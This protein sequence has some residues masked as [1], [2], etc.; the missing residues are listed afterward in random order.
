MY[1]LCNEEYF[2]TTIREEVE[3]FWAVYYLWV[4]F[5]VQFFSIIGI[6]LPGS[7]SLAYAIREDWNSRMAVY[8]S[9]AV[10]QMAEYHLLGVVGG[11]WWICDRIMLK[12]WIVHSINGFLP[13][14]DP[15]NGWLETIV[16]NPEAL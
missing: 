6:I 11:Q 15:F 7:K 9:H 4:W 14:M 10:Q 13:E 1:F 5:W 3:D 16:T 2:M 8:T 12:Y